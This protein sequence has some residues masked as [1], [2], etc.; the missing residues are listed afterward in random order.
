MNEVSKAGLIAASA[1]TLITAVAAYD[2]LS[3]ASFI[4]Y[5]DKLLLPIAAT[6]TIAVLSFGGVFA[7]PYLQKPAE[8]LIDHIRRS[9]E[10]SDELVGESEEE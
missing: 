8:R 4:L 6:V 3:T 7:Y 5:H 9:F 10:E 2:S 1:L